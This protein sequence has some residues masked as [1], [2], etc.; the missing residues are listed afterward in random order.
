LL[1]AARHPDA[2]GGRLLELYV[3][4]CYKLAAESYTDLERL[5]R[6]IAEL[7]GSAGT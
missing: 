2:S 3:E 1:A 7:T 4:R 5:D 6:E